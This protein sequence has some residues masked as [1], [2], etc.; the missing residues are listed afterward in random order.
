[1]RVKKVLK[2][3]R[4]AGGINAAIKAITAVVLGSV[5]LLSTY[6]L[7]V[8]GIIPSTNDKIEDTFQ[9]PTTA[10]A[11]T[12]ATAKLYDYYD[13]GAMAQNTVV[14][15]VDLGTLDWQYT[16]LDCYWAWL[17]NYTDKMATKSYNYSEDPGLIVE[18]FDYSAEAYTTGW[19]FEAKAVDN[20]Y[21]ANENKIYIVD[22]SLGRSGAS[23][24]SLLSGKK[25]YFQLE[26]NEIVYTNASKFGVFGSGYY[27]VETEQ[28]TAELLNH[29]VAHDD[30]LGDMAVIYGPNR[31]IKVTE[32]NSYDL[33]KG[34]NATWTIY[35][36]HESQG[37]Q[38]AYIDIGNIR[39]VLERT[40]E[41]GTTGY[42]D[43]WLEYNGEQIVSSNHLLFNILPSSEVE[44]VTN[45]INNTA[46]ITDVP[47]SVR[48]KAVLK[49]EYNYQDSS[50]LFSV[51]NG[52]K[53]YRVKKTLSNPD[54]ENV[55]V[56]METGTKQT[57][58]NYGIWCGSFYGE[59][60]ASVV[61][62]FQA[63]FES[64]TAS[65]SAPYTFY[66]GDYKYTKYEGGDAGYY[67]SVS[68]NTN[69]SGVESKTG[70]TI[71]PVTRNQKKYGKILSTAFWYPVRGV[72][73]LYQNCINIE[74]VSWVTIPEHA[75]S[76]SQMFVGCTSLKTLNGLTVPDTVTTLYQAFKSCTSLTSVA[77]F[78]IGSGVTNMQ[79][80]FSG[81]TNL[82]SI[83]GLTIPDSVTDMSAT[84]ANC[85][86]LKSAKGIKIGSGVTNMYRTFAISGL[87]NLNG[88]TIPDGV[89]SMEGT[90]YACP[91]LTTLDGFVI[92]NT[93]TSLFQ[94]F[95]ECRSLTNIGGIKIGSGVTNMQETFNHIGDSNWVNV[96]NIVVPEG[97]DNMNSTF[98]GCYMYGTVTVNANPSFYPA[99][100]N[101]GL[102]TDHRL[103]LNGAST[104]LASLKITADPVYR[105]YI[106]IQ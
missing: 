10:V 12:Y 100:F 40:G 62:S 45:C 1:M 103:I 46:R 66:H 30:V 42:A 53:I 49:L 68:L 98:A 33:S 73:N 106:T 95:R 34:F 32:K 77:G 11:G 60:S 36:T 83:D 89:T 81:C 50:V 52:Q 75:S 22:R 19:V 15:V 31:Y 48:R 9:V 67:Y 63:E 44:A 47:G 18:G 4:G 41:S 3:K 5:L 101:V 76:M 84:F 64:L 57:T 58:G 26:S 14:G 16:G 25:L 71:T 2:D 29:C 96:N 6:G 17:S 93:V 74:D 80:T 51:D 43:I 87:E 90:F 70:L 102:N 8:S 59:C 82:T 38:Y 7:I 69:Y 55:S 86:N 65:K 54:F 13:F 99:C 104:M 105:D 24:K 61:D 94:T 39:A 91:S 56:S 88:L 35:F 78:K 21:C 97:V 85:S 37:K 79:E 27:T 72:N 92:P 20:A 23:A 28:G